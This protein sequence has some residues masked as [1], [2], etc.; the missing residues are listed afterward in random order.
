MRIALFITC[1]TDTLYLAADHATREG[2]ERR[3][4]ELRG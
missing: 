1:V 2:A 4:H 3:C